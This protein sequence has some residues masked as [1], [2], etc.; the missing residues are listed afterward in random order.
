MTTVLTNSRCGVNADDLE[1]KAIET[2]KHKR[3]HLNILTW[4]S[5]I[6]ILQF[7]FFSLKINKQK[8]AW[9]L[10]GVYMRHRFYNVKICL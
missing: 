7:I 9:L 1:I 10:G 3:I 6:N 5:L 2:N 4:K 8:L